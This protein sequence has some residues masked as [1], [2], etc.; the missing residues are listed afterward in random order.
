MVIWAVLLAGGEG[1]RF[2][3]ENKLLIQ[4]GSVPVLLRSARILASI[5]AIQ[6]IMV[7]CP[8]AL[9]EEY[10][11]VL[12]P[13]QKP[14]NWAPAGSSR[15]ASVYSGL[16]KLKALQPDIVCIHDAA[17]PL[18]RPE[19]VE[20][21]LTVVSNNE[22]LAASLGIPVVSTITKVERETSRDRTWKQETLDRTTLWQ[23]HTP[24]VFDYPTLYRAHQEALPNRVY[25]D[26]T[27][28][29]RGP[30]LM[31]EDSPE[32]IKLTTPTDRLV[33]E[34]LLSTRLV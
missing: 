7:V 26:D 10:V 22:A 34:A 14:L 1:H 25:T 31:I 29:L 27:S 5:E 6:G 30:V 9:Q 24:Q 20:R 18:V 15:Q 19:S 21:V 33:A 23:L 28:M 17:R 12:A 16:Q 3:E 2:G 8:D 32:N 4:L 11:R 13:L